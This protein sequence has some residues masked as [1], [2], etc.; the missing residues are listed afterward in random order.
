MKVA[1]LVASL[2]LDIDAASFKKGDA[3]ISGMAQKMSGL[4]KA[5]FTGYAVKATFDLAHGFAEAGDAA[6]KASQKLGVNS[7]ALQRL[8]YAANSA[9]VNNE[10]LAQGLRFLAKSGVK[11]VQGEFL[12]LAETFAAMPD[13]GEK[14]RLAL[15][16]FG[17]S[18]AELIP[19][20]NGG[21][22]ELEKLFAEAEGAGLI[23]SPEQQKAGEEFN[24]QL[25]RVRSAIRGIAFAMG[26][27]MLPAF[28]RFADIALAAAK[29][30]KRF[31]DF[32]LE[33]AD[34]HATAFKIALVILTGA[35]AGFTAHLLIA[36]GA[37]VAAAIKFAAA[38]LAAAAPF[39]LIGAAIAGVALLIEDLY[40][41]LTG[42]ESVIGEAV[43]GWASILKGFG[44]DV[45]G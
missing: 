14:T 43:D 6:R 32:A 45:A 24:D 12:K 9:N 2:G 28:K 3:A 39:I 1:E 36:Q 7:E 40:Y 29:G 21:R 4:A 31:A 26:R 27:A 22:E 25:T 44:I 41:F 8:Q 33:F 17:K 42:G 20:L 11:D 13:D 37:A 19:L 15:E 35:V 5:F 38:W 23:I 16:K 10:T 18:G 30:V 34:R